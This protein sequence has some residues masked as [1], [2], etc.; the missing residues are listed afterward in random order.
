[1]KFEKNKAITLLTFIHAFFLLYG[2]YPLI[3]AM[4]QL[5][6]KNRVMYCLTGLILFVPIVLSWQLLRQLHRLWLYLPAG[7]LISAVCAVAAYL[8]GGQFL[9]S[10]G[11]VCAATGAASL[12]LFISHATARI[13]LGSMKKDFIAA[14]GANVP[15]EMKVWEVPTLFTDPRPVHLVWFVCQYVLGLILR[16]EFYWR[17]IF[18]LT[19]FDILLLFAIRYLG[20]LDEFIAENRK[21]AGLPVLTIKKIHRTL[22][23][24]S[25][26][27]ILL[28]TLPAVFYG[29]EPL[30]DA[31]GQSEAPLIEISN[32]NGANQ[33]FDSIN[34]D[35][36]LPDVIAESAD[37]ID[38]PLWVGY[39]VKAFLFLLAAA[40]IIA[41]II[42]IY[43]AIRNAGRD[44]SVENEDEI[45]FLD[46]EDDDKREKIRRKKRPREGLLSPNM[47]IRRRY[48]KTIKK[49]TKGTPDKWATPT[50]LEAHAGLCGSEEMQR[51]HRY[52]E[53]ARYSREGCSR[54]D[55]KQL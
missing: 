37:Q 2:I 24:V 17:F 31:F 40:F 53:Q 19:F 47:Q 35:P 28:F 7:I 23:A 43:H 3:A 22:F 26:L 36:V 16:A 50:E 25:L 46:S 38:P 9:Y 18:F 27:L 52:Y 29:K 51:L 11:I 20:R 4:A 6:G 15:F 8:S 45:I 13:R 14:H 30:A 33:S 48:R 54:E 5:E 1:M 12:F 39:V 55:I 32:E 49:S 21:T 41:L 10:R 44:F 34:Y 42:A